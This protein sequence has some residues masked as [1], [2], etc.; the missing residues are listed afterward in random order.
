VLVAVAVAGF[1]TGADAQSDKA[2]KRAELD[3]KADAALAQLDAEDPAAK[4]L[5]A[6]AEGLLIFPRIFEGGLIIGGLTGD[7]VLRVG[8]ETVGY[9]DTTAVTLG[10]QA[11]GQVFSQVLMFLD[12]AALKTFQTSKGFEVG[13]DANV[14]VLSAGETINA[15]T[16]SLKD[17]IVAFV[18]GES[19][20]MGAATIDG[21][22]D[23]K[24]G[25]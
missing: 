7:G 10:L 16:S 21:T 12:P 19:G 22:K 5:G 23:T 2:A 13:V 14:T 6:E 1:G 25:L 8:G 15:D 11:G 24:K 20:L 4:T 9:D 17:P 3:A 18:F